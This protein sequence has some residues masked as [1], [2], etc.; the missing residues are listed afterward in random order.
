MAA[1]NNFFERV[2]ATVERIPPGSVSTYGHIAR[3]LGIGSAARTVGWALKAASGSGIPA[4]RVVN[5]HG[6]LSGRLNFPTPSFMEECLRAEGVA[7][8]DDGCVIM[9]AHLWDP[10]AETV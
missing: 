9:E 6:A 7:F 1:D 8:D 3:H 2:W 4:H 5:R 10:G